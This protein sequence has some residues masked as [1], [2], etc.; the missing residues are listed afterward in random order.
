M[1][2]TFKNFAK[3]TLSLGY[4]AAATSIVLTGG[5]GA[6][7]PAV[8]FFATW[9]NATDYPDPSDDPNVE[10]IKVT[11]RATDTLTIVRAQE[12]TSASTKNTASKDYKLIATVVA[13]TLTEDIKAIGTESRNFRL[14]DFV[15]AGFMTTLPSSSSGVSNV[16]YNPLRNTLLMARNVSGAAGTI[17]EYTLDGR[18]L[19]TITNSN[20][21]DTEGLCW[22]YGTT[23]AVAEEDVNSPA[24]TPSRISIV[25]LAD[26][27][28]TL[29]RTA[30]G[31]VSYECTAMGDLA[32]LGVEGVCYDSDRH[33]LYFFSEK[34]ST[35][36]AGQQTTGN[37]F[38]WKLDVATGVITQVVN[39][40]PTIGTADVA[41]DLSDIYF[42]RNT[43]CI[44]FLSHEGT[45][46]T[47][48]PGKVIQMRLD[49][50]VVEAI[51][52]GAEFT[53]AE[54]LCF[55]PD[56]NQMFVTGEAAMY[57]RYFRPSAFIIPGSKI[58]VRKPLDESK[59][60]NATVGTDL[61]LSFP[62]KANTT[63]VLRLKVFFTTGATEDFKYRLIGPAGFTKLIRYISRSNGGTAGAF[64]IPGTAYD[65]ADVP[66]AGA[67]GSGIVD[68]EILLQ[69]G[70]TAGTVSFQWAQNTSGGTATIV[71][72]GSYLEVTEM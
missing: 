44:F 16:T 5:H 58:V 10:I 52:L 67:V 38:L 41:D 43:Q 54:G 6:K 63:Y 40:L 19:R 57:A 8:P 35:G 42:D 25:T 33:C 24:G 71:H 14:S 68:E 61:H 21:I 70:A 13:S 23:Y 47:S 53:Q 9:W 15:R 3:G 66:M 26:N 34:S 32:N 11:A 20:F 28:T 18:L 55:S 60:T 22:M 7:F 12:G 29:D 37:W 39:I 69:N 30:G 4:D 2:G 72:A 36:A 1:I 27:A 56:M 50:T 65:A 31:N 51:T 46:G 17:Y 59:S 49:G 64:V 62:V 45:T 48:G